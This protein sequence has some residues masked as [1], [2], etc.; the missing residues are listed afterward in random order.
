M[1]AGQIESMNAAST[2]RSKDLHEYKEEAFEYVLAKEYILANP[3]SKKEKPDY[4]EDEAKVTWF[5]WLAA[6]A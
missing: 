2:S 6:N 3:I 5:Y 1:M 4:S